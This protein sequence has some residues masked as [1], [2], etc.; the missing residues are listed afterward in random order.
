[1]VVLNELI[2]LITHKVLVANEVVACLAGRPD[3]LH[4]MITG[5]DPPPIL[6][7]TADLVTAI[8]DVQ[9]EA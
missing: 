7:E 6:I 9:T 8:N 4:V 1:M 5:T 2:S 3:D